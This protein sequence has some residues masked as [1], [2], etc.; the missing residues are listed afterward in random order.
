MPATPKA[1]DVQRRA[2]GY[3][4]VVQDVDEETPTSRTIATE[5]QPLSC[6]LGFR[7]RRWCSKTAQQS[8][9]TC[10][11]AMTWSEHQKASEHAAHGTKAAN[12]LLALAGHGN[13][14]SRRYWV[15]QE[16]EGRF[17]GHHRKVCLR[18]PLR[19]RSLNMGRVSWSGKNRSGDAARAAAHAATPHCVRIELYAVNSAWCE[20]CALKGCYQ[21]HVVKRS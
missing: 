12:I 7:C 4:L 16:R 1:C 13:N 10:H 6:S 17:T 14:I 21:A 5:K 15:G 3:T 20:R 8:K 9:K 2:A 11:S 19:R 18:T